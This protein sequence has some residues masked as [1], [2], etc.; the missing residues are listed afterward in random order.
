MPKIPY[1]KFFSFSLGVIGI[2]LGVSFY[3]ECR[4]AVTLSPA[5]NLLP[6]HNIIPCNTS[7]NFVLP[8]FIHQFS[9]VL[10]CVAFDKVSN[11]M[12]WN[13]FWLFT[14]IF[15]EIGQALES[16]NDIQ[17]LPQMLQHYFARGI[18]DVFDILACSVAFVLLTIGYRASIYIKR[19]KI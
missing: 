16:T 13:Y 1:L 17:F 14:N 10:V 8:T 3:E 9:L 4:T 18:F 12:K 11:F 2:F 7:L 6:A 5:F 19:K 15:F